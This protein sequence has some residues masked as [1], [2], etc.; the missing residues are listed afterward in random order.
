MKKSLFKAFSMALLA[1]AAVL[2]SC[3]SDDGNN[4]GP[5]STFVLDANNFKGTINDGEVV[6]KTGVT[7]KLSGKL[8][9]ANGAK[10]T[11]EP[12]AIIEATARPDNSTEDIR[13]IAV[14][15]GG[16]I[17]VNGTATNPVVMTSSVKSPGK[18]GGLVICGKAPINK[19]ATASAEV[20]DLTYGGTLANDN[21]GSI[22]YLR[23][24]YSGYA[25]NSEK[26]FNGLSL[27]GVGSGTTI[28]YVQ[29]HE[30]ADDG[31]EFFGGTVNTK[32]L[33]STSNEDDSF[34]WTEGW[35]GTNENWY[36]KLGLGRGNRGI[37]ADNNSNNHLATPIA[38][39]NIK[40]LTLIG[41]G[42]Q[43]SESQALKLRVGTKGQFDNLVLSNFVTGFDVQHNESIGYVANGTLKA[44]NVRFDN[45]TTKS[46]GKNTDGT[47]VDVSAIYTESTTATGA[48]N[49]T[50][51][52]SWAQ[53]WTVGL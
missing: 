10:L 41:L 17:F 24:E 4:N 52:P 49:G 3:S 21:S 29:V 11:I 14:A 33:I 53:G 8:V 51:T 18:W 43:G 46:V 13:Y 12:G 16:Q 23:I 15:Q 7:Y 26:E 2:T 37:E 32:Y 30:G 5:S 1:S 50:A 25:Y 36:G 42:A 35:N 28:E 44:T 20:S 39:P 47:T 34:D 31:I 22:R 48:G 9:V 45:I 6:L 38:N 19:G 27:F 40:N